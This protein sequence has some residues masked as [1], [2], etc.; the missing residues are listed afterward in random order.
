[1]VTS[2]S[3]FMLWDVSTLVLATSDTFICH[4]SGAYKIQ[5]FFPNSS[6]FAVKIFIIFCGF[7]C[8][9]LDLES[10]WT[11]TSSHPSLREC[12]LKCSD[13][14]DVNNVVGFLFAWDLRN[15]GV[16]MEG[17][18]EKQKK[19]EANR[20]RNKIFKIK[21]NIS[22]EIRSNVS[23]CASFSLSISPTNHKLMFSLLTSHLCI[24]YICLWLVIM[25]FLW[26]NTSFFFVHFK[27]LGKRIRR[28]KTKR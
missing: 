3:E 14:V 16:L 22:S 26:S 28:R 1:M 11:W 20:K 7:Y 10:S 6:F 13:D 24:C 21:L 5:H 25:V 8:V 9:T 12:A 19:V 23:S 18:K 15:V 4:N 17:K 27:L 2:E